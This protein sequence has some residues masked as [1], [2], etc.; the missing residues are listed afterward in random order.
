MPVRRGIFARTPW[1]SD[2]ADGNKEN[3][4]ARFAS[5][6]KLGRR[7]RNLLRWGQYVM[8]QPDPPRTFLRE[9]SETQT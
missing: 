8:R 4:A 2:W 3:C 9:E 7:G 6:Q 1:S 5:A